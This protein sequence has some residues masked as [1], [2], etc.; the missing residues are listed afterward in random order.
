MKVFEGSFADMQAAFE[1]KF[2][3]KPQQWAEIGKQLESIS[4]SIPDPKVKWHAGIQRW[5]NQ[6]WNCGDFN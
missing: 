5:F 1:R 4:Q 6:T 2:P 3:T